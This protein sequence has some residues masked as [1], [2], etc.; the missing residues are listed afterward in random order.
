MALVVVA[1]HSMAA[2]TMSSA[3]SAS[4]TSIKN[5]NSAKAD[6]LISSSASVRAVD[7][8]AMD[9]AAMDLADADLAQ[10]SRMRAGK[11]CRIA[12]RSEFS[13][14]RTRRN[15]RRGC[16]AKLGGRSVDV[17]LS[18]AVDFAEGF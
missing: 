1:C 2:A 10:V 18:Q 9:L 4:I 12:C 11:A 15:C 7:E 6:G 17:S 3:R 8:D 16:R 5:H 14:G 13:L